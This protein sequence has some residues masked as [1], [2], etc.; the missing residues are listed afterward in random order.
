MND[1]P[2]C[3]K[4][5]QLGRP[6]QHSPKD[7]RVLE[8][9]DCEY[10]L[11]YGVVV[12][13]FTDIFVLNHAKDRKKPSFPV[14]VLAA[15]CMVSQDVSFFILDGGTTRHVI[16]GFQQMTWRFRCPSFIISDRGSQFVS[17]ANDSDLL[18]QLSE[19]KINF[20]V[21]GPR[22]QFASN[23]ERIWRSVKKIIRNLQPDNSTIYQPVHTITELGNK[24]SL[25]SYLMSFR[26]IFRNDS[27]LLIYPRLFTHL[28]TDPFHVT[29][30]LLGV[31]GKLQQEVLMG[32]PGS[33]ADTMVNFRDALLDHLKSVAVRYQSEVQGEKNRKARSGLY[34][35]A[36]DIVIFKDHNDLPR[37]AVVIKI[38]GKNKVIIKAKHYNQIQELEKH[39]KKISLIFRESDY[40]GHFPKHLERGSDKNSD[41]ITREKLSI[42]KF[43]SCI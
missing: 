32:L 17:L 21:L 1:C 25:A 43:L 18:E 34:P 15:C 27:N 3:L 14:A 28:H 6:F 20:K 2:K 30:D 36:G 31:L 24:L 4:K 29:N 39:V 5:N 19:R 22:E 38:F 13:L 9:L 40:Q 11:Y 42:D 33:R 16:Q 12:D 26:P 8:F 10:P 23:F 7:P 35:A 41:L 37:F